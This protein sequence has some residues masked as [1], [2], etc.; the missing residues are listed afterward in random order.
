MATARY[1]VAR[2][3]SNAASRYARSQAG[4]VPEPVTSN[5]FASSLAL[6]QGL[7]HGRRGK[8]TKTGTASQTAQFSTS[9]QL[10]EAPFHR[11]KPTIAAAHGCGM[12]HQAADLSSI[13]P[14]DKTSQLGTSSQDITAH[15]TPSGRVCQS[16]DRAA[17]VPRRAHAMQSKDDLYPAVSV[18]L[19]ASPMRPVAKPANDSTAHVP[20]HLSLNSFAAT[21]LSSTALQDKPPQLHSSCDPQQ[22]FAAV[23]LTQ[24]QDHPVGQP[25]RANTEVPAGT[26]CGKVLEGTFGAESHSVCQGSGAAAHVSIQQQSR[27]QAVGGCSDPAVCY[28]NAVQFPLPQSSFSRWAVWH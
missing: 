26:N 21:F 22:G 19:P 3:L 17:W 20:Q 11:S 13:S 4:A 14:L 27:V 16:S 24:D 7:A 8:P 12:L 2:Q 25:V 5:S 10:P 6:L 15:G 1:P 23:P 28:D 9:I 18:Q